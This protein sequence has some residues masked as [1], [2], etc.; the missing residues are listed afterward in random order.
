MRFSLVTEAGLNYQDDIDYIVVKNQDGELAILKDH[1]PIIVP[2]HQGHLKCVKGNQNIYAI[3]EQGVLEFKDNVVSVLSLEA[4]IGDELVGT[5]EAFLK[6]KKDKLELTKR[7]N[8]DFSKQEREL[9]E[10]IQKSK[11]GQL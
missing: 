7:E 8:I 11:A 9:K 6:M 2:I 1:I 10:N 4:E 3:I 5:K